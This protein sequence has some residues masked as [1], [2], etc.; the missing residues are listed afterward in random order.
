MF[1]NT[2]SP[3][4][5]NPR[6]KASKKPKTPAADAGPIFITRSNPT[7]RAKGTANSSFTGKISPPLFLTKGPIKGYIPGLPVAIVGINVFG[8]SYIG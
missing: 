5:I 3:S 6:F 7:K 1:I 2:D 8:F 4:F